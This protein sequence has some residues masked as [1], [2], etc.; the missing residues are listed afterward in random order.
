VAIINFVRDY[1][2]VARFRF[3]RFEGMKGPGAVIAIPVLHKFVK[4]DTRVQV[5]EIP[6]QTSITKDNAPIDIDFLVYTRVDINH[7][8]K[9]VLEVQDYHM[10]V[11]GLATTTLRAVL[12]DIPLDDVLSQRE[13]I[14]EALRVRLDQ[15]TGRW[16]IKVTNVEI[17]EIIPPKDI[18]EAMNR[19]MT[20]ERVRRA[21]VL[22]AEGKKQANIT[23][24][25]GEKQAAILKA[26]GLR[27]ATIL[28]ADGDQQAAV[29]RAQGFSNALG[30]IFQVARGVDANTMGLQ[31]LDALK[32]LGA[33]PSSKFIFPLEFT[34]LLGNL[35]NLTGGA[36]GGK[37]E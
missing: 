19:Q 18:Q 26:E 2:R 31:Y 25:E 23:V 30:Q 7:A 17:R 1:E 6:R 11:V 22:E 13:R 33:S 32:A 37:K 15:E 5:L 10:A 24:A 27:Q 4:I 8:D 3:G 36:G 21:V 35:G 12:G 29:L 16:G 9:A 28:T 34:R 20:A 14:N